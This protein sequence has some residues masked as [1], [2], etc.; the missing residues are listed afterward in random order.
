[1]FTVKQVGIG[2]A[3]LLLVMVLVVASTVF[4]THVTGM[5]TLPLLGPFVPQGC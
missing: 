1:M 5:H 3:A 2:L 4:W